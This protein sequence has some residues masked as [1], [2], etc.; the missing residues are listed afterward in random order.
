MKKIAVLL[1]IM[2]FLDLSVTA[3][4]IE[5]V[6]KDF[7]K[8]LKNPAATPYG[9]NKVAGKF[10]DIRGFKMYAEVYVWTR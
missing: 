9:N 8:A 6:M 10:Y 1:S 3:Q 4:D 2:A 5:K 7:E